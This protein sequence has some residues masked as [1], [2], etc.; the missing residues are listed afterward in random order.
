MSSAPRREKCVGRSG[1]KENGRRQN[2]KGMAGAEMSQE[3]LDAGFAQMRKVYDTIGCEVY[4]CAGD[5]EY[6]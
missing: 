6:D 3:D 5:R 1:L 4:I 2:K